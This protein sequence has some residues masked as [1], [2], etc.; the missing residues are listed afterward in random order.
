[1]SVH[2]VRSQLRWFQPAVHANPSSRW[3]PLAS[4]AFVRLPLISRLQ[5]LSV[6]AII[7]V[8]RRI[9]RHVK[10]AGII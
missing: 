10:L 9:E 7:L 5:L 3:R 4:P 8:K 2:R 1:M 6:Y